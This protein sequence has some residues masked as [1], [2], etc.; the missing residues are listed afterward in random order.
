MSERQDNTIRTPQGAKARV[1]R[2]RI[3][4]ALQVLEG[5]HM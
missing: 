1:D 5:D 3:T 4:A 2:E